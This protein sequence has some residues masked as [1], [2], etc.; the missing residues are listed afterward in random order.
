VRGVA[1]QH[2]ALTRPAVEYDL[3]DRRDVDVGCGVQLLEQRR[4]GI[5]EFRE[6]VAEPF[7]PDLLGRVVV[8][9]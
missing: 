2:D 3:L 5:R 1:D 6:Q 9:G 8:W 4:G 7:W